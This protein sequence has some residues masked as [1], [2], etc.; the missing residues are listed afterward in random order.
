MSL[1]SGMKMAARGALCAA[2]ATVAMLGGMMV[3]YDD[4]GDKYVNPTLS[5]M[6]DA[7]NYGVKGACGLAVLTVGAWAMF[8]F[9]RLGR[10]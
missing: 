9:P 5:D 6:R 8:G 1:K 7:V 10:R 2:F 3:M 4:G